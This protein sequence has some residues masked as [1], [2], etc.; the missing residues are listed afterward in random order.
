MTL[1]EQLGNVGSEIERASRW[2]ERGY[3]AHRD[4]AL[5]RALELMDLTL[6]DKRWRGLRLQELARLREVICDTFFVNKEYGARPADLDRYF[7]SFAVE[8]RA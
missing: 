6:S 3:G 4:K 2:E 7:F 1:A 5:D 8:A